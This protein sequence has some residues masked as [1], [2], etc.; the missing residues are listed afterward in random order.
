MAGREFQIVVIR[1]K[2]FI[3]AESWREAIDATRFGLAE[4]G[5][6]AVLVQNGVQP[7]PTPII[8]G[9]HHLD[10]GMEDLLPAD[11]I[12][13]NLEQLLPG[14]P[15]HVPRYLDLLRRF[16]V[17]DFHARNVEWL[18]REGVS[19]SATHV[20]VGYMPQLSNIASAGEDVDVLFYG[21]LTERRQA[22]I[23]ALVARGLNVMALRGVFGVERDK[24]IARAKVVL[25]MHQQADGYFEA[26]RVMHLMANGKA[27]V[28]EC[29]DETE[30]DARLLPGI[31]AVTYDQLVDA[32]EA[33]VGDVD[34][35]RS[36]AA[37]ALHAVKNPKFRMSFIM[38]QQLLG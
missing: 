3:Y 20:P 22:V 15:C 26:L 5:I 11:T 12:I 25:N 21:L 23:K 31:R 16:R 19:H 17:W 13:Y 35:R 9:A 28:S 14:Y 8:F 6:N 7:G 1:P 36:L 27:V 30:I 33:L 32:C 37:K 38:R 10:P 2:G 24:W 18:H 4:L 29:N 34:A